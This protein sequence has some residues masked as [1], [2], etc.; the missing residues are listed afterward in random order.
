[1]GKLLLHSY[2]II[3]LNA[4]HVDEIDHQHNS[5]ERFQLFFNSI[6]IVIARAP[7][8]EKKMNE[9]NLI[10]K[11]EE[12]NVQRKPV[13]LFASRQNALDIISNHVH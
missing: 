10:H 4:T 1:M 9:L 12:K 13:N 8:R 5:P 7:R 6:A 2:F 11:L 3:K